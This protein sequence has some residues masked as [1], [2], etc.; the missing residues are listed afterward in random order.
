MGRHVRYG[1][2]EVIITIILILLSLTIL[3]PMLLPWMF[4]FKTQLEYA[5]DPWAWPKQFLWSNFQDAWEAIQIGQGLL[6][7][8]IVSLGAILVTVPSSAL[9]GYVVRKISFSKQRK[10][11]FYA[12]LIGL[13]IPDPDGVDPLYKLNIKLGQSTR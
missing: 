8:L 12:I 10:S 11:M 4:V 3:L 2:P 1:I 9:A 7:T 5:Y 6:N 13:F